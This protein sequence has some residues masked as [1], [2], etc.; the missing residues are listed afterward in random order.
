MYLVKVM[1]NEFVDFTEGQ[2]LIE[3]IFMFLK[4]KRIRENVKGK[5]NTFTRLLNP[6]LN[7]R[8]HAL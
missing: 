3:L 6:P 7:P 4:C 2:R 8:V 1:M 5:A